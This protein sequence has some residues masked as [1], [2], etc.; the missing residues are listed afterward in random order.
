MCFCKFHV[1]TFTFANSDIYSI[2]WQNVKFHAVVSVSVFQLIHKHFVINHQ[3]MFLMQSFIKPYIM[4][5]IW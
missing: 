4:N 2:L 1:K 5:A 3:M